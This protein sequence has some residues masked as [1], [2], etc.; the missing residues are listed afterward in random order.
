MINWEELRK[1]KFLWFMMM[2]MI[3]SS[4]LLYVIFHDMWGVTIIPAYIW[5]NLMSG[6]IFY[7]LLETG[8][9]DE[10]KRQLK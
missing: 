8:W 3:P 9:R 7:A 6:V 4:T 1:N 10:I 2:W 5:A